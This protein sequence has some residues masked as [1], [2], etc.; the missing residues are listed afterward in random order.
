VYCQACGSYNPAGGHV[1]LKCGALLIAAVDP[2]GPKCRTHPEQPAAGTCH[3]CGSFGCGACLTQR[4]AVWLCADCVARSAVLPWDERET[5]GTWRA[6]WRTSVMMISSPGTALEGAKPE[7]ALGSSALFA[8]L[9]SLAGFGP[10][11]LL[12]ILIFVPAMLFGLAK[13]DGA[14]ATMGAW[15]SVGTIVYVAVLLA[16]QVAG[17]LLL[18]GIDHLMLM[19]LGAQP[20]GYEVSVRANAL[21]LGP[22]LVGLVPYCGLYVFPIWAFVLR[23][24]ALM[25]LHKT[26][27]GKA[28][29]AGLL[30]ALLC[31]GIC[32]IGYASA[33]VV[34]MRDAFR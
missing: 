19:L 34:G 18:G 31:G 4:G 23:I 16:L 3:R 32:L 6:W 2:A 8:L 11:L 1:C 10:T 12:G 22:A 26:S 7:G 30:P 20:R 14:S 24:I 21:A 27:G 28:T 17:V 5:L 29:L 15:V 9:S 25:Y 33:F 13:N